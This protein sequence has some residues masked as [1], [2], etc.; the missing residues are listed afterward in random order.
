MGGEA[1]EE[2]CSV[3]IDSYSHDA[4]DVSHGFC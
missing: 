2:I 3:G 1:S 4:A